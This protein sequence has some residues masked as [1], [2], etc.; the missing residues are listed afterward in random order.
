MLLMLSLTLG[1]LTVSGLAFSEETG[2]AAKET[3]EDAGI[4]LLSSS[5][6]GTELYADEEESTDDTPKEDKTFFP[7]TEP[8]TPLRCPPTAPL[9][10]V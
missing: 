6:D 8:E 1:T 10:V 9:R 4:M 7:M 2:E 3:G 5:S